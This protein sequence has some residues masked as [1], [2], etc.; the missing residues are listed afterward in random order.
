MVAGP[1]RV[2]LTITSK[3][4]KADNSLGNISKIIHGIV[5]EYS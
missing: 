4:L 5:L 3:A 1:S 2:E